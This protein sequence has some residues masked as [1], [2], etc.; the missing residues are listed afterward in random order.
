MNFK[1]IIATVA[2][3]ALAVSAMAISTFAAQSDTVAAVK[4]DASNEDA[5]IIQWPITV[6]ADIEKVDTITIKGTASVADWCGGGGAIGFDSDSW[7]QVDFALDGANVTTDSATGDFTAVCEFGGAAPKLDKA[8]GIVQLG[9]WWGS[10]DQTM[11]L[12]DILVNG[13]SI[14][15]KTATAVPAADDT[16]A[17]EDTDEA[18]DD[19]AD[20]AADE[21][22]ADEA[23]EDVAVD[24]AAEED[25]A[26][27]DA[28]EEDVAADDTAEEDVAADDAADEDVAVD[29]VADE[30]VAADDA[31][32]EDVADDAAADDVVADDAPAAD[33]DTTAT[34]TGN[35]SAA[36]ILSVMAV[37][38]AVAVVAKK[39]K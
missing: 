7:K 37:A 14:L 22:T 21:V 16:A 39:R 5:K 19:T 9:W 35:V 24:D 30:D 11:Q 38:G 13:T 17:A 29:D 34:A 12:T 26:V 6:L 28:A 2:A 18:L 36:V 1:K 4:L 23:D 32:E 3:A 25:V 15:G 10:G 20:E 31:A 33:A 8:D 27:D